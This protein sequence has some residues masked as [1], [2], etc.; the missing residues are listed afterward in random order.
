MIIEDLKNFIVRAE[1]SRK[2]A[3]NSADGMKVA[4]AY[5]ERELND[6]EKDS[7]EKFETNFN[8]IYTSVIRNNQDKL[9]ASS[10]EIY[11][12]RVLTVIK[13]YKEYDADPA[14]FVNW[15]PIRRT[16]TKRKDA[17]KKA[18]SSEE[19]EAGRLDSPLSITTE[20]L[21]RSEIPLR[22]GV[23]AI[24]FTPDDLN[25]GDVEKINLYVQYLSSLAKSHN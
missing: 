3:P 21:S 22:P 4:L 14:K 7:L 19:R 18:P 6:E 23:K 17:D 25:P 10:L 24:I 16:P 5:F 8:A 11:K 1:K 15:N 13:D 2:Y 12:R 9:S 20:G